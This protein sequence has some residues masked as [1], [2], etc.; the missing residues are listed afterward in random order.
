MELTPFTLRAVTLPTAAVSSH[1]TAAG[2][3][4]AVPTRNRCE[5]TGTLGKPP[6]TGA[7]AQSHF[8]PQKKMGKGQT[9]SPLACVGSGTGYKL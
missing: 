5:N 2:T 6:E 4:E 7:F 1:R 9:N 8:Q 3:F